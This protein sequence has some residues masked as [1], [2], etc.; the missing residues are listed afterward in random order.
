MEDRESG[1][2]SRKPALDLL[3]ELH[4][5]SVT[6]SLKLERAPAPEGGLLPRRPDPVRR[7][8]RS[9]GPARFDPRGRGQARTRSDAGGAGAGLA[10]QSPRE[11]AHRAGLH[12][13]ARARRGGPGQ[14]GEDPDRSLHLEGGDVPVRDEVPPQR[15]HRSR[16]L[17]LAVALRQHPTRSGPRLGSSPARLAR[18]RSD[19]DRLA[20]AVSERDRARA[21]RGGGASFRRWSEDRQADRRGIE[22][23]RVRGM[24]GARGR[25]RGRRS[26]PRRRRGNPGE[27]GER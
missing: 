9:Q 6:G 26:E 21:P 10:R 1:N 2:L 4:R 25:A 7:V 12:L 8:E 13:A 22:P 14:G 19:A 16:A 20:A 24:Q 15:R 18:D 17:H 23:R 27:P 3:V 11:G 5:G